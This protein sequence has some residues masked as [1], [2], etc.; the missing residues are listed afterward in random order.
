MIKPSFYILLFVLLFTSCN[1]VRQRR[2]NK[3]DS[4]INS[5][6]SDTTKRKEFSAP[7][8]LISS[9]QIK[10]Y[11]TVNI[12][13]VNF[14]L[15]TDSKDDTSFIGTRDK[16]FITPEGYR[17]GM[18]LRQIKKKYRDKLLE[19]PGFGYFI[20]LPSK[21]CILFTVGQTMTEHAPTDTNKVSYIY[22]RH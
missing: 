21:W 18:S 15:V 20:V 12:D 13:G 4:L 16:S 11:K 3:S 9:S 22:R 10:P 5:I 7:L 19:E 6:S 14:Q 17:V 2:Q 8:M 1:N